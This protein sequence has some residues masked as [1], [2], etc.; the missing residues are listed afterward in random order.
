MKKRW[1]WKKLNLILLHLRV[2]FI[3]HNIN[4]NVCTCTCKHTCKSIRTVDVQ[5][6]MLNLSNYSAKQAHTTHKLEWKSSKTKNQHENR[7]AHLS[8][9]LKELLWSFFVCRP[10]LCP[11]VCLLILNIFQILLK[12]HWVNFKQHWHKPALGE[13]KSNSSKGIST[14]N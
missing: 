11:S 4:I 8:W 10:Y 12:N 14:I 6:Q 9:T 3:K 5:V 1:T 2:Q 13:E 7:L